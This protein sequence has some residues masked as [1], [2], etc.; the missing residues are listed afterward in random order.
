M[1]SLENPKPPTIC[2]PPLWHQ[3]IS[4]TA[5]VEEPLESRGKTSCW[6]S[7]SCLDISNRHEWPWQGKVFLKQ[8]RSTEGCS[9]LKRSVDMT[10][11]QMQ[12]PNGTGPDVRRSKGWGTGQYYKENVT[13]TAYKDKCLIILASIH[14]LSKLHDVPVGFVSPPLLRLCIAFLCSPKGGCCSISDDLSFS[15]ISPRVRA[16]KGTNVANIYIYIKQNKKNLM[17]CRCGTNKRG[18]CHRDM[19][20]HLGNLNQC[21]RMDLCHKLHATK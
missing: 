11:E 4:T 3:H 6:V 1:F 13:T 15:C 5:D 17:H 7:T 8:N 2:A 16:A 14:T 18:S 19:Y 20:R 10:L 9:R 12:V 21:P